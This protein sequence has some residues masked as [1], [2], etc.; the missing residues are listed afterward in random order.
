MKT[1][2]K[3]ISN[4]LFFR[5]DDAYNKLTG[6]TRVIYNWNENVLFRFELRGD[7]LIRIMI[8]LAA[9]ALGIGVMG[10]IFAQNTNPANDSVGLGLAAGL[11]IIFVAP[12]A[13]FLFI[14][15]KHTTGGVVVREDRIE[16][17]RI[18]LAIEF[19]G[20]WYITESWPYEAIRTCRIIPGKTLGK[21]FS[22]MTLEGYESTLDITCIP[23]RIDLKELVA[24]LQSKGVNVEQGAIVPAKDKKGISWIAAIVA[25][26]IAFP[27]LFAGLSMLGEKQ[28]RI[29]QEIVEKE[30]PFK[31]F[32]T[33][34]F[35]SDRF[36]N[37]KP[38][39]PGNQSRTGSNNNSNPQENRQP[40]AT[41]RTGPRSVPSS[42]PTYTRPS[43]R[44]TYTPPSTS[45]AD[46][47]LP[48]YTP[49]T[50]KPPGPPR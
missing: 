7:L 34:G 50:Y 39:N 6:Q 8:T 30:N 20:T 28:A 44:P 31:K 4:I 2:L 46:P 21:R 37:M 29:E 24:F 25:G 16:R 45:R 11:G 19:V 38:T 27:F 40:N 33:E 26:V 36:K 49:P 22:L 35:P 3:I 23:K 17:K 43:T 13:F 42:R 15:K 41:I 5:I 9:W 10:I 47:S 32:G 18:H 14:R 1:F 48:K 12:V